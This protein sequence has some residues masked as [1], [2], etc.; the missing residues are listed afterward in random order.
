LSVVFSAA[1]QIR[2]WAYGH[3]LG[4]IERFAVPVI[5][6]GNLT[7][8]GTGKTP[9]TIWLVQFLQQAGY[10][11]GVISRGYGGRPGRSEPLRVHPESDPTECGDEPVLI[12][13]KTGA[14][15]MVARNRGLAASALLTGSSCNILVADDGLQHYRL[16][17]DV[18]ILLVDGERRFGNGWCLPAGPLR[19]PAARAKT[20]DFIVCREG[21]A[22]CGEYAMSLRGGTAVNLLTGRTVPLTYF[23]GTPVRAIAGI[24]YPERFFRELA[25][26]GMT[27]EPLDFPDHHAYRREDLTFPDDKPVLMTEKDAVKCSGFQ[28]EKLWYV[29][30]QAEVEPGFG[31]D[32]LKRLRN[33]PHG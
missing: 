7:V 9:L 6:V 17:R 5:V 4:K 25:A 20:V 2:R 12:A 10:S 3:G 31:R 28:Q 18:E 16:G 22:L 14:P 21:Q 33:T 30:V 1:A 29:P 26:W 23:V 13:Q 24:G 15:V 19:E 27:V 8:G 32:L 11:P